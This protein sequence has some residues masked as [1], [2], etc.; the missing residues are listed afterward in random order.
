[1]AGGSLHLM[2]QMDEYCLDSE[3]A[4]AYRC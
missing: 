4:M 2:R 1:M 3:V